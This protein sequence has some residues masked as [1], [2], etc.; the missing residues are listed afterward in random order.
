MKLTNILNIHP[1]Q[2][3]VY[4]SFREVRISIAYF[5][6]HKNVFIFMN[7]LLGTLFYE[8]HNSINFDTM[9][10][11]FLIDSYLLTTYF[12]LRKRTL[13]EK[14]IIKIKEPVL[15]IL[16]VFITLYFKC[17]MLYFMDVSNIIR[18]Y[19]RFFVKSDFVRTLS[20]ILVTIGQAICQST[21]IKGH[22]FTA[23]GVGQTLTKS[24][25]A[26]IILI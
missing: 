22:S 24:L 10:K 20:S 17:K 13:N 12:F 11:H 3:R 15:H 26:W 9:Q 5:D 14:I 25:L 21:S 1:K 23:V 7:D 4:L 18:L 16:N 2:I 6:L 8:W 19:K